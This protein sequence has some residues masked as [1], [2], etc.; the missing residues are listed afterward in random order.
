MPVPPP[1]TPTSPA[2]PQS[3]PPRVPA[4]DPVDTAW[5]IYGVLSEATGRMD[6][7]ASFAL[8]VETAALAGAVALDRRTSGFSPAGGLSAGLYWCGIAMLALAAVLA[9]AVVFP[10]MARR[11]LT[12]ASLDDHI[13]FGHLR[14]WR[15]ADLRE[16]LRLGDPMPGLSRQLIAMS[17]VLWRKHQLVQW[18]LGTALVGTFLAALTVLVG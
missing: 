14:T 16:R 7:K 17:R 18:S 13:Y 4:A 3:A 6:G 8:S 1:N 9:A 12:S 15:D 10:R 5:R 2:S 11:E